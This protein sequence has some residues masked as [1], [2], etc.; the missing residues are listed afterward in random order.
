MLKEGSA[1]RAFT[2]IAAG[3]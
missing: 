3:Y 2:R 1:L